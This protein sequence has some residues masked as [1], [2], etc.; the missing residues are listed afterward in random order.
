MKNFLLG[1][2]IL[3]ICTNA[4]SFGQSEEPIYDEFIK[5]FKKDYF[6]VEMLF[7]AVADFQPE[8]TIFGNNSFYLSNARLRLFGNLDDNFSYFF[9]GSFIVSPLLLDAAIGYKFSNS[10]KITA[11]QF[12]TPFSKE[13]LTYAANIDFVNR[14]Q[15]TALL[16]PRRDLGFQVSGL[17]IDDLI[18]Y[19]AGIFNGSGPNKF[20]NDDNSFLYVGRIAA[21][22]RTNNAAYEIGFNAGYNQNSSSGVLGKDFSGKQTFIG[23]DVRAEID[24]FLFSSEIILNKIDGIIDSISTKNDPLGYHV[25]LGYKPFDRHQFLLRYDNLSADGIISDSKFYVIGYNFWP[26]RVAEIQLNY[27][28]D[29]DNSEFKYHWYLINFQISL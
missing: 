25:T 2:F 11:G 14:A 26:T 24:K 7:Q 8:R 18:E 27:I 9:Q 19:R 12:K 16:S 3:L 4:N 22:P 21:K 20:Y 29:S 23:G 5:N 1:L 6:T 17:I 28:I 10:F 13:Y 15:A